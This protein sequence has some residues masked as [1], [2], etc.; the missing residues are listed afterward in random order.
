MENI[1]ESEEDQSSSTSELD[2]RP[3]L[4]IRQ[5]L[6]EIGRG[7]T[8]S[9][10]PLTSGPSKSG[11]NSNEKGSYNRKGS[12]FSSKSASNSLPMPHNGAGSS[13]TGKESDSTSVQRNFNKLT[14]THNT[15]RRM[16]GISM[17]PFGSSNVSGMSTSSSE[18]S[19][20][21]FTRG[22][23]YVLRKVHV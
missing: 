17:T 9:V 10:I 14:N 4:Q 16:V 19:I 15:A 23:S 20:N 2:H 22:G 13:P 18:D 12:I 7:S 11:S 21:E 3:P 8:G 1:I 5:S 6:Q